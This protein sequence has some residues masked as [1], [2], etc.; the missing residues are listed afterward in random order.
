MMF[1]AALLA[2]GL[3]WPSCK[4]VYRTYYYLRHWRDNPEFRETAAI[5]FC[6]YLI[7][8]GGYGVPGLIGCFYL[9]WIMF[10]LPDEPK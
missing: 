2:V 6:F 5:V 10:T 4:G 9:S 8:W 7:L 1:L 3:F